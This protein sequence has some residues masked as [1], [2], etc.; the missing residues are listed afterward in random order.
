M[1]E[2]KLILTTHIAYFRRHPWLLL[3]FIVGLSLGSALLTAIAGLNQEA[4]N[5]HNTS[6]ALIDSAVSH[7]VKPPIG[8]DYIDGKLWLKLRENGFTNAQPVLRG[9]L[10]LDS[11]KTL[12]VQGINSL[13]WMTQPIPALSTQ[14]GEN[15]NTGFAFDAIMIDR[16]RAQKYQFNKDDKK[17]TL[18]NNPHTPKF[19]LVDDIGVWS[20][21]DIAYAD[22]LLSAQGKLSFIEFTGL[23]KEQASQVEAI[24]GHE[25]RLIASQEQDFDALSEAFFFNLTAL[26]LLGYIVAAFL[27]FNA[28]KLS[29]AGRKKLLTQFNL[30]GCSK[31]AITTA[32]VIE[33][34]LMSFITAL[35]GSLAG[36]LIANALVLDINR[37]LMGLYQL[38]K[39][40]TIGWQWQTLAL[41]FIVNLA[42]LALMVVT[43]KNTLKNQ[44][45]MLF[46]LS[47]LGIL[48]ALSYLYLNASTEFEALLLCF[49]TLALFVLLTPTCLQGLLCFKNP[50]EQP[51]WQWLYADSKSQLTEL[52]IAIVAILVAL[53]SA[54]GMQIM[55]KSFSNTLNA[56]LE[57]QLS[58]DMYIYVDKYQPELRANLSNDVDIQRVG[59][60]M[61]S[62][63]Y[64]DTMPAK[65]ASFG[66]SAEAFSH[67][68]LTS[69]KSVSAAHFTNNGCIANEQAL[70]KHDIKL[71]DTVTFKQN[72]HSFLCRISAFAY[73][74]GNTALGLITL[75][76]NIKQSPLHWQVYGLSLTLNEQVSTSQITEKLINSYGVDSTTISENKRF[77]EIANKLFN[78]TF[79]VTKV[80]NGFILAIALISLCISLLSLSAQHAK[81]LAVLN[82]LGVDPS[83]LHKLKLIQTI[84]LVGFTCL[85]AIPLGLAL[86][87]ALL[88]YVMPI[89]F[90]WTIHFY[91][92]IPAL[93]STCLFLLL[94]AVVCAY[95]PVKRLT[96][97]LHR[98]E[99]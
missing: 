82:S 8:Q 78:D 29:I 41:G 42:T 90:G 97:S 59:I 67:I 69:G 5:R 16:K 28:I 72:Q 43:Q 54:I 92:D 66:N 38:D 94:S 39:A 96:A 50:F 55:V 74:Y 33:F 22:M 26:A 86:G 7:I 9:K 56:H 53:G 93:I 85:F 15:E 52:R 10:T 49:F 51:L 95:L 79:K 11:G 64:I 65:L 3:L 47:L 37:T 27:S 17:L 45:N 84:I 30:L 83:Q 73:D 91:L 23:T 13:L 18:Q 89:A 2:I 61:A 32:I 34:T 60:Y 20:L 88:K 71:N 58:A 98:K 1:A 63:G 62:N 6:S 99:G 40:L 19:M 4:E 48:A 12:Y 75:E 25:A 68:N 70:I 36:F 31:Q 80:L 81:Q 21:T 24:L 44:G 57:K 46:G 35:L 76:D 77:K 87:L 14:T